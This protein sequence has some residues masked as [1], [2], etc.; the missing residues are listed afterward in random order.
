MDDLSLT[1]RV[2][3]VIEPTLAQQGLEVVDVEQMSNVIRITVDGP[4]GVDL[5]AVSDASRSVSDQLDRH[6]VLPGKC[7]LEVSSPGIER[8]LRTAE[9]F[10]RA[11]GSRITVK[12]RP[13]TAPERRIEAVLTSADDEGIVVGEQRIAYT[14]IERARTVFAWGKPS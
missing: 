10:R 6:D 13:G 4:D 8:P 2:R 7:V 3:Q 14:D 5:D 11:V 9:H 1:T 12:V